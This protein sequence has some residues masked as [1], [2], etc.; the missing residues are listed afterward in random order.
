MNP[1]VTVIVPVYNVQKYLRQCIDSL[2]AQTYDN[3]EIILVDDG[4]TDDSGKICDEYVKNNPG[5]QVIHKK[6]A[7]LGFARNSGMSI[8]TG[9]Y[10]TFID[11]DDY[12]DKDMIEELMKQ[13]DEN[14]VDTVIGG[15][16][17]VDD[18]GNI[19]FTETYAPEVYTGEQAY[20]SF[21]MR[22]LGSAPG[23]HDSVRMSVWN[24]VYN[25]KVIKENKIKFPSERIMIS[26]DIVFDADYYR[27]A[28]GVAIVGTAKYNYRFNPNSLTQKYRPDI[29][30]LNNDLYKEMSR[31]IK[32]TFKNQDEADNRLRTMYLIKLR[33]SIRQENI[34]GKTTS[35][36]IKTVKTMCSHP[37]VKKVI[38]GYPSSGLS[39]KQKAFIDLIKLKQGRILL[40]LIK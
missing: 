3:L 4:S 17:K 5:L 34:S 27:Y 26:E 21:F 37:M 8:G 40:M 32:G 15:F 9:D 10:V 29:F 18:S 23:K 12:C 33:G 24:S 36:K 7:G 22:I 20:E 38:A 2:L 35:E 14:N 1:K 16:K 11:S 25:F 13:V 6:N 28:K 30:K 19:L 31:K 39:V